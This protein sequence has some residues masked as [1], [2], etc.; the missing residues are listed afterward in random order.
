MWSCV[1]LC[2]YRADGQ[3][4][5]VLWPEMSH[6]LHSS[7]KPS[8]NKKR[9]STEGGEPLL[10]YDQRLG[11]AAV[12]HCCVPHISEL[13]AENVVQGSAHTCAA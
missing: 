5:H 13:T 12:H 4:E 10:Q 6:L 11:M 1:V 3:D 9:K 8:E 2:S 7:S